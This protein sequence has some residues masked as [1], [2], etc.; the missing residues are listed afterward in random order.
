[1]KKKTILFF[2][3]EVGIA[4]IVRSL[5]IAEELHMRGHRAL[6]ALPARKHLLIKSSPISIIDVPAVIDKDSIAVFDVWKNKERVHTLAKEEIAL[7]RKYKADIVVGDFRLSTV[8]SGAY[9]RKPTIFVTGTA[10]MP[11]GCQLPSLGMPAIAELPLRSLLQKVV[12]RVRLP[13]VKRLIE[14]ANELGLDLPHTELLERMIYIVPE[15]KGYLRLLSNKY[16]D[17]HVGPLFWNG[18]IKRKKP[19]WLLR[20]NRNKKSVYLSF[21]GTGFDKKKFVAIALELVN[22]GYLVVVSASSIARKSDFS[23]HKRLIVAEYVPGFEVAKRVA[24]VVCHGGYG[25]MA[26][27]V[28]SG[29]PVV[30][31][32]FN[33]DQII[34]SLRFAE[35]GLGKVVNVI[36]VSFFSHAVLANWLGLEKQAKSISPARIAGVVDEVYKNRVQYKKR[37]RSSIVKNWNNDGALRA[38][39]V[40]ERL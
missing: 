36:N 38:A 19:A 11:E 22:Q 4:H 1:M 8:V 33:P 39:D 35:L 15:A 5:A 6:F 32:P 12:W 28:M 18:F 9:C 13:Y 3:M 40:I 34:H 7:I 2:P 21:G 25:T 17:H 23:K 20:L 14:V 29:T 30:S 16:N 24:V 31:V 10:G 37:I 26:Q 27:A